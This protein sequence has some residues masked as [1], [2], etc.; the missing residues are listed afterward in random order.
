[1]L[2]LLNMDNQWLE[3]GRFINHENHILSSQKRYSWEV[4]Y[5]YHQKTVFQKELIT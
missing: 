2:T 4:K 5:L 3:L 1:M